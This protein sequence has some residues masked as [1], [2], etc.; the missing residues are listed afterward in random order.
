MFLKIFLF[1][2][3]AFDFS[4][5]A[6][7]RK[8]LGALFK[9]IVGEISP[10]TL[11][12]YLQSHLARKAGERLVLNGSREHELHHNDISYSHFDEELFLRIKQKGS[13]SGFEVGSRI[14]P[15]SLDTGLRNCFASGHMIPIEGKTKTR[16][17]F[18]SLYPENVVIS[19]FR[20]KGTARAYE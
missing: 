17:V 5:Q 3:L 19:D 9:E 2:L 13:S 15:A 16:K 10:R 8:N 18:V 4:V 1:L 14:L 7:A 20:N 6:S 11:P 12:S